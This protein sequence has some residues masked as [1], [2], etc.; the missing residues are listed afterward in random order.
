MSQRTILEIITSLENTNLNVFGEN[1]Q[2]AKREEQMYNT[3]KTSSNRTKYV[4]MGRL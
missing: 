1:Y 2:N 3:S 4:I